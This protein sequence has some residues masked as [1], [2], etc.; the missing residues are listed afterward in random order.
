M[1][2]TV[3]KNL[4][5]IERLA[6]ENI[7][8]MD[9]ERAGRQD[10]RPLKVLIVNL[11]PTK[12]ATETQI[13]RALS[14]TP[15]QLEVTLLHT[16]S[17]MA[18]NTPEEYLSTFY[19]TFTDIKEQYFD[20]MII[21]GAPVEMMPFEEV[22]Y[23]QELTEIMK[24]S[25]THVFSTFHICWGAQAGLYYHYGI[26]KEVLPKKLFGVYENHL[27][28]P[29]PMLLKGFDEVFYMPHSR[30]TTICRSA[31]KAHKDL[32]I[33]A[34]SERTGVAIA[35]SLDNK[36]IFVFGHSEYDWDTL[37]R[38]YFRDKEAGIDIAPPEHY[39]PN[40]DSTQRPIVRW[41][42]TATLLFT[43][44]LNY[45]VYQETPYII[46]KINQMKHRVRSK[47]VRC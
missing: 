17:Y 13:L 35:R 23:W 3:V 37:Q 33:L 10:I 43:N 18:T 32:E 44:W 22:Q 5:A 39:Y 36:H 41:R 24:W 34:E 40:D 11:M 14:N 45:Y 2:I 25:D 19:R 38:E 8:V 16:T 21:T 7:F 20:G 28:N 27:V 47:S 26:N 1:P 6:K 9:T 15:I 31:I 46:E 12:E 30:H 42:S 29:K 4:P